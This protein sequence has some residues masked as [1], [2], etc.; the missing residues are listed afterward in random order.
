MFAVIAVTG[1]AQDAPMEFEKFWFV[2]LVRGEGRESF[3]DDQIQ[4][5]QGDHLAN[6]DRMWKEKIAIVAGPFGTEGPRRGFVLI[7]RSALKD[8]KAV[9]SEFA[10]DPFVKN[11]LLKV[12][13]FKW[14]T[15]K[16]AIHE[17]KEDAVMKEYV[18]VIYNRPKDRPEF[19]DEFSEKTQA[20]H[21]AHNHEMKEKHKMLIAGPFE[22]G[23]KMRGILIFNRA[24]MEAVKKIVGAD[25]WVKAGGLEAEFFKLYVAQGAFGD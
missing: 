13:V 3:S 23:G 12:E 6:I 7:K 24:D 14:M 9:E 10:D 16:S 19:S 4:K 5:M 17:V 1:M 22:D 11:G 15:T 21:L 20:A 8:K 18:F 25:P 2:Y